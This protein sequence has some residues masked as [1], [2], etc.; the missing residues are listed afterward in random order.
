MILSEKVYFYEKICNFRNE[1]NE[2][3]LKHLKKCC[4]KFL[5][6]NKDKT[7]EEVKST[8]SMFKG[9]LESVENAIVLINF[10][11]KQI[12]QERRFIDENFY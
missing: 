10:Y 11:L 12:K 8:H 3:E 1:R 7:L 6:E 9:T 5:L 2:E 4:E